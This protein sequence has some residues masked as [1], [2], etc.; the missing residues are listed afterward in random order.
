MIRL[1]KNNL[2][3]L[4]GLLAAATLAAC[5]GGGSSAITGSP[6][7]TTSATLPA[8]TTQTT[9]TRIT[10]TISRNAQ[11]AHKHA[12]AKTKRTASASR[13]PKYVSEATDGV[14][15]SITSGSTTKTVYADATASGANCVSS[16]TNEDT[17]SVIV[18]TIGATETIV[19]TTVDQQP[20]ND[21]NGYGTGFPSNTNVLGYGT[22][23]VAPSGLGV[24]NVTLTV[25]PVVA[26]YYDCGSS[27]I[28]GNFQQ[29][30][31]GSGYE[32]SG[33]V[34]RFVVTAG[35]PA[36]WTYEPE[37]CDVDEDV[38]QTIASP[39]PFVDVNGSPEPLTFTSSSSS[40][41][42]YAAPGGTSVASP[43]P[44]AQTV[45]MNDSSDTD[46]YGE[47]LLYVSYDGTAPAGTTMTFSNNLAATPPWPGTVSGSTY[48][49]QLVYTLAP[50]AASPGP[51]T[52]PATTISVGAGGTGTVYG[53]DFGATNGMNAGDGNCY[54]TTTT[55]QVD[56]TVAA[57]SMNMTSWIEPFTVT[58]TG[59]PPE[60][61]SFTLY[62]GDTNVPTFP[63]TVSI[64]T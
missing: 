31:G 38:P 53:S 33:T 22:A 25:D 12:A 20:T 35:K 18:P 24:T 41:T 9:G 46:E 56:A 59:S 63:I 17:C 15:V 8:Q 51:V 61:C 40:L 16:G 43:G 34:A 45:T 42:M 58:V 23:T 48:N 5:G 7:V 14:Q 13:K 37:W 47:M 62:D 39:L 6:H 44:Y 57:G 11:P 52:A 50:V 21:T 27:D 55:S 30:G 64:T 2:F 10:F 36:T 28:S 1:N 3:I 26:A 19:V 60:T 49:L 32:S 54:D 4:G 29:D